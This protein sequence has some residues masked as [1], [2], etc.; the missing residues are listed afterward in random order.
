MT[1]SCSPRLGLFIISSPG[2]MMRSWMAGLVIGVISSIV[3]RRQGSAGFL[4]ALGWS[5][6][7]VCASAGLL[8]GVPYLLS[9]KP[10]KIDGKR[11]KLQ[12]EL[13]APATLKIPSQPDGFSIRVSLFI[14]DRQSSFAFI[15]WMESRKA[16]GTLPFLVIFRFSRTA[17]TDLFSRRSVTSQPRR[18]SLS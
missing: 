16:P 17:K 6:L 10:P 4:I 8:G 7:I 1:I 12:F 5:L 15:D 18:N 3:I 2:S 13:R 9:D 14:D 11:L